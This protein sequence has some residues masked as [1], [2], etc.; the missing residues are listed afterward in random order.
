MSSEGVQYSLLR[1]RFL[2]AVF[3]FAGRG[4][5]EAERFFEVGSAAFGMFGW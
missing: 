3:A 1:T 5:F 2:V 4:A